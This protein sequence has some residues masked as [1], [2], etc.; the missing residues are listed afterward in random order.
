MVGNEQGKLLFLLKKDFPEF[1]NKIDDIY[2]T[3]S[4]FR[5]I[6]NDYYHIVTVLETGNFKPDKKMDMYVATMK[7]LKE[8][9]LEYLNN[10]ITSPD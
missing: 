2:K 3:K 6:A 10:L 5:E 8:E 7:E 1:K 4:M 9:L